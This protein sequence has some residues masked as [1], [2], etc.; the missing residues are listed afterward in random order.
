MRESPI[1]SRTYD[2]TRWILQATE[3]FPRSQRFVLAQRLQS[4]TFDLHEALLAAGLSARGRQT[5]HLDRADVELAK[6]RLYL[7]LALDMEWLSM[8]QY[9]HASRMA[10]EIGRLLGGWRRHDREPS[11]TP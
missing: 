3:H 8:G 9:E 2:L 5:E 11:P 4:A 10:D 7:R 6:V 1:F